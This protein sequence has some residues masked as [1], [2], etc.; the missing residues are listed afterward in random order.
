[1]SLFE[2]ID[3]MTLSAP[4]VLLAG[5]ITG[6]YYFRSLDTAYRIIT[7][8]FLTA[9][10]TDIASRLYVFTHA[11]NM[12][13][14]LGFSL[15]ELVLFSVLYHLVFLKKL[16]HL[17]LAGILTGVFFII[18]EIFN[19][20]FTPIKQFQSYAKVVDTFLI[21]LLSVVFFLENVHADKQVQ[22]PL[23]RLNAIILGFF[24]LNLI[25]FLPLNFMINESSGLKFYLWMINLV[26]TVLFYIFLT[27]EIWKNGLN[28]KR[29]RSG[30]SS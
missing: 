13:F 10:L 27:W 7:F 23:F 19:L 24:S 22:W 1:M 4:A 2:L 18:W 8:Y 17:L 26:V 3:W 20:R 14:I 6:F 9:F 30:S 16:H 5:I 12:I 11:D 29:L 28:Q 15:A 21:V 25:F